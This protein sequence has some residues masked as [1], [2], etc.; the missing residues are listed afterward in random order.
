MSNGFEAE[1]IRYFADVLW[2]IAD[3]RDRLGVKSEAALTDLQTALLK[4]EEAL[5]HVADEMPRVPANAVDPG[6]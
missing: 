3:T 5:R 2:W 6:R 1:D 4:A